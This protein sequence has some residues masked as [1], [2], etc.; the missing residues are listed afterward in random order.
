MK[1]IISLLLSLCMV[2]SIGAAAFASDA[3]YNW[4][5]A[6]HLAEDAQ[7]TKGFLQFAEDVAEKSDGRINITVSFGAALGAEREL[8]EQV[9]LGT[10]EMAMGEASLYSNYCPEFGVLN[11]PFI[12][13]NEDQLIDVVSGP[14]GE[15]LSQILADSTNLYNLAW[16]YSGTR[17][18]YAADTVTTIAD[19]SGMKIRTPE[20]PV[21]VQ[22]FEALGANPTPI[23]ANEMYTSLQQHVVD[24]ME[25]SLETA[26]SYKIYEVAKNC[27]Q[28]N[29]ILPGTSLVINKGV[30]D[31]LPDDLKEVL[32]TCAAEMTTYEGEMVAESNDYYQGLL[33]E[34][35]VVFTPLSEEERAN[36]NEAVADFCQSYIADS[37]VMQDLYNQILEATK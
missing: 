31:A 34:E 16:V 33:E 35:G 24:A 9:N 26:Y 2:L 5:L 32:T 37:E 30:F 28:T 15:Q 6:T 17:D 29:H 4:T 22:S 14:A 12:F 3:E 7:Q 10:I 23:A 27:L 36:A 18:I 8:V 21:F 20:S 25:G 1:K 19:I 13:E 11:L